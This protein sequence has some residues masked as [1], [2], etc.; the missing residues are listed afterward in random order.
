MNEILHSNELHENSLLEILCFIPI[1]HNYDHGTRHH[2]GGY[3][4]LKWLFFIRATIVLLEQHCRQFS[5]TAAYSKV[6]YV[7]LDV[8][9]FYHAYRHFYTQAVLLI[10]MILQKCCI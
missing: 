3:V 7:K 1:I 8:I 10:F 9:F 5:S 6:L 2:H 4:R